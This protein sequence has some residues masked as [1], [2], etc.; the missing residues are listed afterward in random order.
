[1]RP[2]QA[3][4]RGRVAATWLTI[5]MTVYQLTVRWA[6][7]YLTSQFSVCHQ[8][9]T[10]SHISYGVWES[11]EWAATIRKYNNVLRQSWY[12]VRGFQTYWRRVR[13]HEWISSTFAFIPLYFLSRGCLRR[14][15]P[16][17]HK[18]GFSCYC[19]WLLINKWNELDCGEAAHMQTNKSSSI[20]DQFYKVTT[21][22]SEGIVEQL[23]K[24]TINERQLL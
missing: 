1:M 11:G 23:Y 20:V 14:G 7:H 18:V 15:H 6:A 8:F 19:F 16:A 2:I 10:R 13:D 24:V 3:M 17:S 12:S 5:A 4:G 9:L 21:S 22:E